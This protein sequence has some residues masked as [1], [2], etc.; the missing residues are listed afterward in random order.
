MLK[1][2]SKTQF[3][4]IL[5]SL[6]IFSCEDN[7]SKN[8]V[9]SNTNSKVNVIF[10]NTQVTEPNTEKGFKEERKIRENLFEVFLHS[11]DYTGFENDSVKFRDQIDLL[12]LTKSKNFFFTQFVLEKPY[13]YWLNRGI[14]AN[15][16][17]VSLNDLQ[18][19]QWNFPD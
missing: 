13:T 3:V 19:Y 11:I 10:L 15:I 9:A 17:K 16:G 12:N 7:V 6:V 4:F 8:E 5:L 2:V 1:H 18:A 14:F